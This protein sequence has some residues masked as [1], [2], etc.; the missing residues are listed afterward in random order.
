MRNNFL[1]NS[2]EIMTSADR[3]SPVKII[4]FVRAVPGSEMRGESSKKL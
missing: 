3:L 1:H 2:E 4:K